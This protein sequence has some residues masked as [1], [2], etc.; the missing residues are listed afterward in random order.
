MTE[1]SFNQSKQRLA[2][3]IDFLPDATFAID[4]SEKVII[5]NRAIEEMTGVKARDIVGRGD[6]EYAIPF[7][8]NQRPILI[9][10]ILNP[11]LRFDENVYAFVRRDEGI[12][13]TE[14]NRLSLN[15]K[16]V[17]L[18]GKAGPLYNSR[19][20]IV[21]AVESIRNITEHK[22]MELALAK[23]E[24]D[25]QAKT[26]ELEDLNA[27]LRVLL[28]QRDKD[29]NTIAEKILSNINLFILPHIGQLK[30]QVDTQVRFYLNVLESN[31]KDIV[32]PFA[33]KLSARFLNLTKRE[34]QIANLI[35]EGMSTK[36]IATFL[37]VSDAAIHLHRYR[38]RSKLNLTKKQNLQFYLSS[39]N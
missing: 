19:G 24:L 34:M 1:E 27:T 7:Y 18:W 16:E 30:A 31:L 6:Y 26:H 13:L 15:N 11:N 22:L 8:G 29:Q 3:I 14:T 2:N 10:L 28:K 9:N 33:Q 17:Y 5:W 37:N 23:R 38:I 35:K 20:N 4:R 21:G 39:L 12:L 36:E 25:L 32:S